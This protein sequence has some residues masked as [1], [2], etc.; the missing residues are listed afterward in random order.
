CSIDLSSFDERVTNDFA[1][2][3]YPLLSKLG[4]EPNL[5]LY[6]SLATISSLTGLII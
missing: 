1:L 4:G 5:A 6:S 2:S 3:R